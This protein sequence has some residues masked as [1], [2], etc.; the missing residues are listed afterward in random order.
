[1][2]QIHSLPTP[3][4]EERLWL[5]DHPSVRDVR[6]L[7]EAALDRRIAVPGSGGRDHLLLDASYVVFL[8]AF[9]LRIEGQ[10]EARGA[11]RGGLGSRI[12]LDLAMLDGDLDFAIRQDHRVDA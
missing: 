6:I 4:E 5:E 8:P 1:M 2:R 11:E 7:G 9:D 12:D 10:V 3:G